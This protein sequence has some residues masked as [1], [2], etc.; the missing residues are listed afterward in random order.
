VIT[1][2]SIEGTR[3]HTTANLSATFTDLSPFSLHTITLISTNN[4]GL[5]AESHIN[6]TT[7]ELGKSIFSTRAFSRPEAIIYSVTPV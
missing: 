2:S 7:R 1:L 3:N 5:S 4:W 6:F